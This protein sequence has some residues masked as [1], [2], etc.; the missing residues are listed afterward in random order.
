MNTVPV[1]K[2]ALILFI[3]QELV[4]AAEGELKSLGLKILPDWIKSAQ[5]AITN[6][7]SAKITNFKFLHDLEIDAEKKGLQWFI[8][9]AQNALAWCNEPVTDT[10]AS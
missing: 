6:L 5:T 9:A 1:G 2:D 10:S 8:S 7:G 3:E 4:E